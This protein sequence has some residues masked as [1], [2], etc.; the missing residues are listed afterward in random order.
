MK[1][2]PNRTP[3]GRTQQDWCPYKKRKTRKKYAFPEKRPSEDTD[4]WLG[5]ISAAV[6][7]EALRKAVE[8]R[9]TPVTLPPRD[10]GLASVLKERKQKSSSPLYTQF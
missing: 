2:G 1:A 10:P 6:A 3:L 7:G 8:A 4:S 5:P 9:S